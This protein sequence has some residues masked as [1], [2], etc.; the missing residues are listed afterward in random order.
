MRKL[1]SF[2]LVIMCMV[3]LCA[4]GNTN[5]SGESSDVSAIVGTWVSDLSD[6]TETIILKEELT[7]EKT[8]EVTDPYVKMTSDGTY[9]LKGDEISIK[10]PDYFGMTSKYTVTI[11]GDTMT[12][13]NGK[14]KIVYVR[15]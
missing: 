14:A 4:C 5:G 10:Y 11:E 8:I 15:K 1:I 9:S 2:I 13:D 12:W 6:G 7:Y 3:T